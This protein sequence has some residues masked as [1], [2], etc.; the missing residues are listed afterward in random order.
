MPPTL[1]SIA[2]GVLV[3]I[4]LLGAA[5]DRRSL[6]VVVIAAGLPDVD[7]LLSLVI[8]GATNALL[9]SI[10]I[11]VIAAGLLYYDTEQ[12]EESWLNKR[13]GWYGVRVAWVAI[14]SYVVAGIGLDLFST[15]SVALLYPLS[16][17]YYAIVGRFVL[18][19]QEGIVQT[20]IQFGD[21][22]LKVASPGTTTTHHVDSWLHPASEDPARRLRLI[23]SGWQAVLVVTAIVAIPA[24]VLVERGDR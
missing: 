24:K 5:F 17:R 8:P 21:G 14:G 16:D 1:I 12:R 2:V 10:L 4:A 22:W 18:S 19:T 13:Y 3:G 9:H 23:E 6:G 20:Y 7:A 11:P 15:E